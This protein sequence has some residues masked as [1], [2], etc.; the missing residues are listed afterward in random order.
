MNF[1]FICEGMCHVYARP[2]IF[3]PFIF[4]PKTISYLKNKFSFSNSI[5]H[6]CQIF[7][8]GAHR[9]VSGRMLR[10]FLLKHFSVRLSF[11]TPFFCEIC[12]GFV[13][14]VSTR[15]FY[16]SHFQPNLKLLDLLTSLRVFLPLFGTE[17]SEK[18]LE[19]LKYSVV[20]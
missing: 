9:R 15:H 1:F 5:P 11:R 8:F 17:V 12:R 14:V 7:F 2:F 18:Y 19:W 13:G 16:K 20:F 6:R 3:I 4:I 10:P